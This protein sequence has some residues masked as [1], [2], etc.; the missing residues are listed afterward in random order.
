MRLVYF[1]M[2]L[3]FQAKQLDQKAASKEQLD[4]TFKTP[5]VQYGESNEEKALK[6]EHD[7]T[8]EELKKRQKDELHNIQ[9]QIEKDTADEEKKLKKQF[10][11]EMEQAIKEKKSKQAAEIAARPDLTKEQ[12]EAVRIIS[13]LV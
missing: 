6:K 11:K 7:R 4:A 1:T 2:H 12:M 3:K 8:K 13:S 5:S 9:Q 10:E